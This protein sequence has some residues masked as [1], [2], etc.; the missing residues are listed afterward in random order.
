MNWKD[1]KLDEKPWNK[2]DHLPLSLLRDADFN[3]TFF[4]SF[5]FLTFLRKAAKKNLNGR[6]IKAS[7]PSLGKQQKKVLLLMAGPLR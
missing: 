5:T 7:P 6:A 1:Q 4:F 2:I 3:Y